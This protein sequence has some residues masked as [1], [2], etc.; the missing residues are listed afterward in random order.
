MEL[1]EIYAVGEKILQNEPSI[2]GTAI[3]MEVQG[4]RAA[5]A[6]FYKKF[7]I[8][9]KDIPNIIELESLSGKCFVRFF[10]DSFYRHSFKVMPESHAD[11]FF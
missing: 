1:A 10:P 4:H 9:A 5:Q 8:D 3:R 11:T 6:F 7:S 2:F